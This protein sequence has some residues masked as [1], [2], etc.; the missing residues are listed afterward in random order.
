MEFVLQIFGIK[1]ILY[2][3]KKYILPKKKY[4]VSIRKYIQH[5]FAHAGS[6]EHWCKESSTMLSTSMS[7]WIYSQTMDESITA[8]GWHANYDELS[9][10]TLSSWRLMHLM[11][12]IEPFLDASHLHAWC[13]RPAESPAGLMSSSSL[14]RPA[15]FIIPCPSSNYLFGEINGDTWT[16]V[17]R[18][19]F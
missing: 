12:V 1:C 7:N 10:K 14:S 8:R 6:A 17:Q 19:W 11:Y 13:S 2:G 18:T 5:T 9:W 16:W 15:N 3:S 4:M